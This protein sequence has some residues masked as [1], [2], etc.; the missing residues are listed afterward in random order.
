[1]VSMPKN[2]SQSSTRTE[3]K[4]MQTR[5]EYYDDED[6][7]NDPEFQRCEREVAERLVDQDGFENLVDT[8]CEYF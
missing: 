2:Y 5:E 7:R 4:P 1:M 3:E 8:A 6:P